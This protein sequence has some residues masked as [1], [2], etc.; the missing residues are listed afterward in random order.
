MDS[1]RLGL[2]GTAGTITSAGFI[3]V[4]EFSGALLSTVPATN[5]LGVVIATAVII[6]IT[7]VEMMFV[8]ALLSLGA[9]WNWWPRQM[10]SATRTLQPASFLEVCQEACTAGPPAESPNFFRDDVS[11]NS[12]EAMPIL[13]D[14]SELSFDSRKA[15]SSASRDGSSAR[16]ALTYVKDE[17]VQVWSKSSQDWLMATVVE[18]YGSSCFADGYAVRGGTHTRNTRRWHEVDHS[19]ERREPHAKTTWWPVIGPPI[20]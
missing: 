15:P 1:I 16:P 7:L 4:L 5:Q 3:F 11:H 10:P 6:D 8:P 13:R 19:G 20:D 9:D 18:V 12:T 2:A 14:F 17:S